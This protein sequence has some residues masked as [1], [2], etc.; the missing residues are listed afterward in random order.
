[1]PTLIP[2]LLMSGSEWESTSCKQSCRRSTWRTSRAVQ[3]SPGPFSFSPLHE[4][5]YRDATFDYC[6]QSKLRPIWSER[7]LSPLSGLDRSNFLVLIERFLHWHSLPNGSRG[8]QWHQM[9]PGI[10]WNT[11]FCRESSFFF[12]SLFS[13]KKGKNGSVRNRHRILILT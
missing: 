6:S 5:R 3:S 8:T 4:Q 13:P 1:M 12:L 11:Q 2:I 9:C 10:P 7:Y